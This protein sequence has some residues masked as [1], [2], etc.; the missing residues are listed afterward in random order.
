MV[1]KCGPNRFCFWPKQFEHKRQEVGRY[2]TS[3]DQSP[4][5]H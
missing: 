5:E 3:M 2:E 4:A 1:G